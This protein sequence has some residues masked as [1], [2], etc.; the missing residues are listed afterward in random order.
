VIW[1]SA[2]HGNHS[3]VIKPVAAGVSNDR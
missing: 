1:T 2:A 3:D